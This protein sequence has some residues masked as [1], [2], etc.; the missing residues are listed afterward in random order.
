MRGYMNECL[1][2]IDDLN[3]TV[4]DGNSY[5]ISLKLL[6]VKSTFYISAM[7]TFKYAYMF[8]DFD[9]RCSHL[10]TFKSPNL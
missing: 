6:I 7:E 8:D 1:K 9:C 5:D 3:D 10:T 4:I 2:K